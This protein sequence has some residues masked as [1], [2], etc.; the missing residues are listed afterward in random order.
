MCSQAEAKAT[1]PSL[2]TLQQ[3]RGC[4]SIAEY[5]SAISSSDATGR[6]S[7]PARID[8]ALITE[9]RAAGLRTPEAV[10]A[11]HISQNNNDYD[12]PRAALEK[13]LA[14]AEGNARRPL[15]L[16]RTPHEREIAP[17]EG[18]SQHCEAGSVA[19]G[20][21][22]QMISSLAEIHFPTPVPKRQRP[23][24]HVAACY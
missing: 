10:V 2:K 13:G 1:L 17:G 5:A 15:R 14:I 21:R 7:T 6:A 19:H 18:A 23:P 16:P 11:M 12:L 24:S 8:A 4:S 9:S 22:L 3:A 20:K